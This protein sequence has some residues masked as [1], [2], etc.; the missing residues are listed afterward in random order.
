MTRDLVI[1]KDS[2]IKWTISFFLLYMLWFQYAVTTNELVMPMCA[3]FMGLFIII[4]HKPVSF[5]RYLLPILGFFTCGFLSSL[6]FLP[7]TY[8]MGFLINMVKYSIPMI[9]IYLYVDRDRKK[10]ETILWVISVTCVLAA[11]STILMGTKTS[12]GATTLGELNANA[13]STYLMLGLISNCLLLTS[14]V[15]PS[16]KILLTGF[17]ALQ[18]IAQLL[19]ASRRGI[20][21]FVFLF[22]IYLLVNLIILPNSKNTLLRYLLILMLGM[23]GA[24]IFVEELLT[25]IGESLF[26]RRFIGMAGAAMGDRLRNYY[27]EVAR[28]L[29]ISSPVIGKG[30]G[31]VAKNAG[32][33]A[34]SLYYETMACT[35]LVGMLCILSLFWRLGKSCLK[36]KNARKSPMINA[37]LIMIMW[38]IAA[39]LLAGAA[40]VFI[41][42]SVFYILIAIITVSVRVREQEVWGGTG[43]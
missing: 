21:V 36:M 16:K 29:F 8:G 7:L 39:I 33:Y 5:Y 27:Q 38:S 34:H 41:Y 35:G 9:A 28:D 26:L 20:L 37:N 32:V 22:G 23:I 24:I 43:R 17:I 2:I 18:G 11:L 13:L 3:A 30:L 1:R 14:N 19:A 4:Q 25:I 40:V 15:S 10:L 12:T 6:I 42:D 31:A